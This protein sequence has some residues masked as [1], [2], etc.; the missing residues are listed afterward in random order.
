MTRLSIKEARA[1][2]IDLRPGANK[3]GARKVTDNNP[4]GQFTA[5]ISPADYEEGGDVG[6]V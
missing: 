2:G 5:C 3:Y 1:L 4:R 6:E